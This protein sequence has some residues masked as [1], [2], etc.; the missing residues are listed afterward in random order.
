MPDKD[1]FEEKEESGGVFSAQV[2]K[3]SV[4]QLS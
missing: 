1:I 4:V 2:Q 3:K